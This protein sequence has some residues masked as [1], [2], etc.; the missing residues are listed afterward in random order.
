MCSDVPSNA[1]QIHTEQVTDESSMHHFIHRVDD[2]TYINTLCFYLGMLTTP[3]WLLVAGVHVYGGGVAF[4]VGAVALVVF[5]RLARNFVDMA[6]VLNS[7]TA[8]AV[9]QGTP[10]AA[11]AAA[12]QPLRPATPTVRRSERGQ[13]QPTRAATRR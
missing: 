7:K 13:L 9:A 2:L 3:L 4:P 8:S 1:A 10:L 6:G 5:V 12:A 11:V